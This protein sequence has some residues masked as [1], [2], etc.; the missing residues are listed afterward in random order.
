MELVKIVDGRAKPYTLAAFRAD[1]KH[2]VYGLS[3]I[4]I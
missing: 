1:N 2:I 3:L 4:H